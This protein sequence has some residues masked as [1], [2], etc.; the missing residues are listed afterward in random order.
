[1][2]NKKS[3]KKLTKVADD[4]WHVS[5][6]R[7]GG[8]LRREV[9]TDDNGKVIQYNLAYISHEIHGGD[10]GRVLGYDNAHG[11]HHRHY[12]GTVEAIS[13]TRFEDIEQQFEQECYKLWSKT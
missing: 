2:P 5:R 7:G 9:W 1:M 11:L 3:T 13:L 4:E 6:K 8:K 10:N 12:M